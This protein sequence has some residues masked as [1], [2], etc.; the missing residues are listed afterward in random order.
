MY[1]GQLPADTSVR[2]IV[3]YAQ[4]SNVVSVYV[5]QH[6]AGTSG[7]IIAYYVKVS[8]VVLLCM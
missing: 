6:P 7:R 2:N 4:I 5:G 8:K 1:V 3:H